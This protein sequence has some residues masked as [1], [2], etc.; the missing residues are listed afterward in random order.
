MTTL[1][2]TSQA[3]E[4][5]AIVL[6]AG[7]LITWILT[8]IAIQ[9]VQIQQNGYG[10]GFGDGGH[11]PPSVVTRLDVPNGP[12]LTREQLMKATNK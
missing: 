7:F 5:R 12:G 10:S 9:V 3:K 6:L 11:I 1:S 2:P 8:I 4:K